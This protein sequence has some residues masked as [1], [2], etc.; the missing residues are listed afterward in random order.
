MRRRLRIGWRPAVLAVMALLTAGVVARFLLY[1]VSPCNVI[2][3]TLDTT[4]ADR[5][6]D[7][8]YP[9]G[10]T[11][12]FEDF[13]KRGVVFNHAYAPAPITLPSHATML[14]GLY[15][16][17]HGLRVNGFGR[18]GQDV[19]ILPEI[20]KQHGYDTGAFI[21]A[22]VLDSMYGLAR[23]FD[24]Y[25][26]DLSKHINPMDPEERR[27]DGKEVVDSALSWLKRRSSRPF[28]CWI[29]LYDAHGPYNMREESYGNKFEKNPYDAGIAVEV[30]QIERVM[31]FL[32]Q[33]RFDKNTLIV[34]AGDHGE[35]LEEHQEIEHGMLVYNTTLHVPF[36]FVGPREIH[37]GLRVDNA[38]SLV[39]L[40]PT[41]LDFLRI[42]SPKHVSGRSLLPALK[43]AQITSTACYAEAETPFQVNRWCPLQAA[44]TERWKYIHTTRPELYDLQ[45][46]PG[47]LINLAESVVH[48]RQQMQNILESLQEAFVRSDTQNVS[49][50][51]KDRANL[52]ALGYVTGGKVV[53]DTN[54]L[55]TDALPDVKD[56]LPHLAKYEKARLVG[57]QGKMEQAV[58]LLHEVVKARPDYAEAFVLLGA[59]LIEIGRLDEG[60]A[61]YQSSLELRP[62]LLKVRL[63]LAPLLAR[64]GR[65]AD[66]VT[67]FRKA[68]K[69]KPVA[70]QTHFQFAEALIS[71]QKFDEAIDQFREAI[72]KSPDF[73]IAIVRLGETLAKRKGPQEAAACFEQALRID[74]RFSAAR[75][76]L[77][78]ALLQMGEYGR[79]IELAKQSVEID[80]KSFEA[81]YNLGSILITQHR[82]QEGLFE[83]REALRLRPSDPRPLQQI[84]KAEAALKGI[85]KEKYSGK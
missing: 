54:R 28:F 80:P 12:G 44:V 8:G 70:A 35:G 43:G 10:M 50:S 75:S 24:T 47:E 17:E 74:R 56:M 16:P 57:L 14:T 38:V 15:P 22:V 36:A 42:P 45:N 13:A 2:L 76:G 65:F 73:V 31:S 55:T 27:R 59:C 71:I 5:L 83:L 3:I 21:A 72:R 40:M 52:A 29:H 53:A 48:E 61:S 68:I 33:N 66:A 39:D 20:L 18:L 25:D 7:Y 78:G 82:Y 51:D 84:Q 85:S 11:K 63:E 46:D 26:D 34:V 37:P 67:E 23:G 58:T 9:H 77:L 49:L 62:D 4:R 60:I 41:V 64:Q 79:A 69:H 6:S 32:K 1:R 30:E 81:R 19:P